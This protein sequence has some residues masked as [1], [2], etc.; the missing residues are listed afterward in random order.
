MTVNEESLD[1]GLSVEQKKATFRH[2]GSLG[3]RSPIVFVENVSK[4]EYC[5]ITI[6]PMM[7][8]ITIHMRSRKGYYTN[9]NSLSSLQL[10][11]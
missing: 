2:I 4:V 7:R 5:H 8:K 1:V 9:W 10:L 6:N 3:N 11:L